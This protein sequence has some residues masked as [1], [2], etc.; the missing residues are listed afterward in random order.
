MKKL[1]LLLFTI[2]LTLWAAD[3]WQTKSF[4][5]WDEKEVHKILTDSPWAKKLLVSLP[6][7]GRG[8]GGVAGGG[9]NAGAGGRGGRGGPAG[10]NYDPGVA[11]GGAPGIAETAGGGGRGGGCSGRGRYS[12][13][14]AANHLP[15]RPAY[16]PSP[17]QS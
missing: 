10:G 5:D 6:M 13:P 17:S 14:A 2:S 7:G 15:L 8:G 1:S 4:T 11:G 9:G 12:R 16:P 3:F